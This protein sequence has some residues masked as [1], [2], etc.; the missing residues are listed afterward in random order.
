[1]KRAYE[2]F[3]NLS[4][5]HIYINYDKEENEY[6]ISYKA[7]VINYK[8]QFTEKE[9]KEIELPSPLSLDMFD[10]VEVKEWKLKDFMI[11]F[12]KKK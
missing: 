6:F 9:M 7:N 5:D 3:F 1:M 8:T 2:D 4:Y 10:K 12:V 11:I